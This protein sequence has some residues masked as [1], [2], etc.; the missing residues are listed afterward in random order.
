MN[1]SKTKRYF[2]EELTKF[3]NRCK[4]LEKTDCPETRRHIKDI[5]RNEIS[6]IFHA[7]EHS[8]PRVFDEIICQQFKE[9][10]EELYCQSFFVEEENGDQCE[11]CKKE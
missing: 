2:R 11:S 3:Q 9:L 1:I 8:D 7:L 5:T 4:L 10:Y 6:N